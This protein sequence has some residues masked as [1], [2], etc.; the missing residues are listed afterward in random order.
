MYYFLY[1]IT[2][3][4]TNDFYIGA[5]Q[6]GNLNDG[7][8]GSGI[9]LKRA[10]KKYG[11]ENFKKVIF[12]YFNDEKLMYESESII[13]NED[14]IARKDTYNL[15]CGGIGGLKFHTEKTKLKIS[16]SHT[17]KKLSKETKEK[18]SKSLK[19]KYLGRKLS[20][21][22]IKKQTKSLKKFY[23]NGGTPPF[24]GKT[25][26]DET[27]R[28]IGLASKGRIHIVSEETRKKLSKANT[29]KLHSLETKRKMSLSA[30]H[31]G[32]KNPMYGNRWIFNEK[33]KQN[34]V[35]KQE[36]INEYILKGWKFGKLKKN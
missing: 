29:G 1:M 20:K 2:C 24:K 16:K 30:D 31:N 7:Y 3:I 27:K 12:E 15:K 9:Y 8:L 19:G 25:H 35:I 26:S 4:I 32:V 18:I 34:K 14:F 17:G 23:K 33:L 36:E 22:Q 11:E 28:K 5:H 6:T 13:V 10:I 21:E